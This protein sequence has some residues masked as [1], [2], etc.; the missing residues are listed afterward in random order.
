MQLS[1]SDGRR[2]AVK[3]AAVSVVAVHRLEAAIKKLITD[4]EKDRFSNLSFCFSIS[5]PFLL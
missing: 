4:T 5:F 2:K 3:A 1:V